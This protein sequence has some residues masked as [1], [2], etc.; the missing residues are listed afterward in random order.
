MAGPGACYIDSLSGV[1][2]KG[3]LLALPTK[4]NLTRGFGDEQTL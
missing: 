1:P 2:L 4:L 3:K